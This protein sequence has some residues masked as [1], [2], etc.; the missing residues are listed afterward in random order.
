MVL[1]FNR[2]TSM[3]FMPAYTTF[4]NWWDFSS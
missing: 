1:F 4:H 2:L 3:S